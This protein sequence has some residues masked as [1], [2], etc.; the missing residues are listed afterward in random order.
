M[1]IYTTQ[2]VTVTTNASAVRRGGS[3]SPSCRSS[4]QPT[5]NEMMVRMTG[6]IQPP[7]VNDICMIIPTSPVLRGGWSGGARMIHRNCRPSYMHR[8]VIRAPFRHHLCT[9][10]RT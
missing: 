5:I 3:Q 4:N 7:R 2:A 6:M 8:P 1:A 9:A 10:R